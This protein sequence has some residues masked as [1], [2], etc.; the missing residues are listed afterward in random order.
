[1][2]MMEKFK[3]ASARFPAEV[4]VMAIEE[5]KKLK[6]FVT[7]P[8]CLLQSFIFFDSFFGRRR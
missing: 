3:K 4:D 7:R 6:T 2:E 5:K 8:F 1:M